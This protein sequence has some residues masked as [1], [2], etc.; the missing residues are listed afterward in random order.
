M[1]KIFISY[2]RKSSAFTLLLANKLSQH[3]DADIFVDF[4]SIDQSDFENSILSHL[5][6]SDVFLLMITE[7]TFADRIH[8]NADW[9]RKEIQ[10]ALEMDIPIVLVSEN[11]LYPPRDLPEDIREIANRQGIEFYPAYFDAAVLRLVK[12]LNSVAHVELKSDPVQAMTPVEAL[13]VPQEHVEKLVVEQSEVSDSNARQILTDALDAYD[14]NDFARALFLFEALK[15][16]GYQTR[17]INIDEIMIEVQEA[18]EREERKRHAT[19]DYD[20]IALFASSD[21]TLSQALRAFKDWA[22]ENAE[23]VEE[24]DTKNLRHKKIAHVVQPKKKVVKQEQVPVPEKKPARKTPDTQKVATPEKSKSTNAYLKPAISLIA[25]VIVL[26]GLSWFVPKLI[27]PGESAESDIEPTPTF[28]GSE[29]ARA[30]EGS[31]DDWTPVE[32]DFDGV[33]MVL[34]PTGCFVMGN[35]SDAWY[36]DNEWIT[37]VPDGGEQCFNEPFWIDKYEV[38]QGNF[39]RLDGVQSDPSGFNGENRPVKDIIW[40]EARDFCALRGGRLP[41]EAEWEFVARGPD[42]LYFPWGNEWNP[43]NIVWNRNS[44]EGTANVGSIPAGAS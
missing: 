34:V 26:A 44:S 22:E 15:D 17:A 18:Y 28:E 31:N 9:V 23:F 16:I 36:Y 5:R 42:E 27:S 19:F 32:R 12:F 2:R 21:R 24:L 43:D 13:P 35:D 11:G 41:T 6:A 40:F 8:N 14:A 37:G 25:T 1:V 7:H 29:P 3:L 33:T 39:E 38:T 10:I 20:E 4:E 30:F